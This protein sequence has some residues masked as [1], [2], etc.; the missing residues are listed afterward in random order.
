[1]TGEQRSPNAIHRHQPARG[2]SDAFM[3]VSSNPTLALGFQVGYVGI[4]HDLHQPIE[5][6]L[7]TPPQLFGRL[8][9]IATQCTYFRR[10][11]IA[12][13]ELDVRFEIT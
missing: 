2:S 7:W 3:T 5:S 6:H 8:T 1:M 9:R 12:S 4:D 11:D 10:A 13:I